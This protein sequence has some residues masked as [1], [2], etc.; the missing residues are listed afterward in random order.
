M[1]SLKNLILIDEAVRS[2]PINKDIADKFIQ[3][4]CTTSLN[5]NKHGFKIYR[6]RNKSNAYNL[7]IDPYFIINPK[8]SERISK[9]TTNIYTA[10]IDSSE[11]WKDYP[12]RS[13]SIIAT[14]N[15]GYAYSYG[16]PYLVYLVN[17]AK[18]GLCPSDDFWSSFKYIKEEFDIRVMDDFNGEVERFFNKLDSTIYDITNKSVTN[19]NEL[20]NITPG[21]I[22]AILNKYQSAL[23]EKILQIML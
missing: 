13:R 2:K 4:Y 5:R 11:K 12:K 17:G 19:K 7:P 6:G 23:T 20:R 9:N 10:L 14:T 15:K 21:G 16:H 18:I 3:K 22:D 8:Q 1:I